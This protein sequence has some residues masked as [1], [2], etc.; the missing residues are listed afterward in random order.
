[1]L[2]IHVNRVASDREFKPL[3]FDSYDSLVGRTEEFHMAASVTGR[4]ANKLTAPG[5]EALFPPSKIVSPRKLQLL[6]LTGPMSKLDF[7]TF[8]FTTALN[9]VTVLPSA[10]MLSSCSTLSICLCFT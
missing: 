5:S 3:Q 8:S 10:D 1:M 9:V 7:P 2:H 6:L 4:V